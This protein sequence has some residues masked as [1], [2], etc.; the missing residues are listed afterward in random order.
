MIKQKIK[1]SIQRRLWDEMVQ[2][3]VKDDKWERKKYIEQCKGTV[4]DIIKI[5]LQ[6]RDLKKIYEKEEEQHC[7]HYVK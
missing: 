2:K 3:T 7:A 4:K 6:M 1:A 5:R